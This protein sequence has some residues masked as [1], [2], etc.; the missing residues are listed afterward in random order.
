LN[1]SRK[2]EINLQPPPQ[3]EIIP[4]APD[5]IFIWIGGHWRPRPHPVLFGRAAVGQDAVTVA[6]G[7]K[8]IGVD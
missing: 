5:P 8:V 4:V 7:L 6:S 1:F 3:V 2:D